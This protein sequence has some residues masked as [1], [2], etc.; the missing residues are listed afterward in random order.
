MEHQL[1]ISRQLTRQFPEAVYISELASRKERVIEFAVCFAD[2]VQERHASPPK[3]ASSSCASLPRKASWLK[4]FVASL[5]PSQ[6]ISGNK[7]L[8]IASQGR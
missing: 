2:P 6:D 1:V 4:L 8:M 7:N 5:R 3:R